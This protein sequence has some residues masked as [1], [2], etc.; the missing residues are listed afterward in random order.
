MVSGILD[1]VSGDDEVGLFRLL[2]LDEEE[3][4]DDDDDDVEDEDDESDDDDDDDVDDD[5]DDDDD[6]DEYVDTDDADDFDESDEGERLC[7][8]KLDFL[9]RWRSRCDDFAPISDTAMS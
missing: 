4:D 6:D 7:F 1:E 8:E 2:E 9:D 3:D 5:A